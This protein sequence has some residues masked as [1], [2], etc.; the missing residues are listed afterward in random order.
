MNTHRVRR[1]CCIDLLNSPPKTGMRMRSIS[2]RRL[3]VGLHKLEL[4]N[5]R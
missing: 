4:N 1:K 3:F 5:A 2:R